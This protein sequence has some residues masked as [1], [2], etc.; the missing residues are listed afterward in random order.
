MK[1][2]VIALLSSSVFFACDTKQEVKAPVTYMDSVSYAVGVMNGMNAKG[3]VDLIKDSISMEQ[4]RTGFFAGLDSTQIFND[5][6]MGDVLNGFGDKVA[7]ARHDDFMS[8]KAALEG[9]TKTAS[10]LVYQVITEGEGNS[11]SVTDSVIV[12]YV[13]RFKD[14]KVFDQNNPE[15]GGMTLSLSSVIEGWKEGI[16]LMK[17]GAKY[18]FFVPQDLAYGERGIRNP[19][20]GE[21]M[22]P[23]YAPLEFEV[24]LLGI[25]PTK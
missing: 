8:E 21:M 24:E 18:K 12:N 11:P 22:M 2:V 3:G 6:V 25:V 23:A 13:G 10:G 5:T 14:G 17:T 15:D 16:P 9:S 1:K 20:T 7:L 19:R 4:F